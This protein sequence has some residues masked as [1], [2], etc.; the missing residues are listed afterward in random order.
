M[1]PTNNNKYGRNRDREPS[2]FQKQISTLAP[3]VHFLKVCYHGASDEDLLHQATPRCDA[4]SPLP[5]SRSA[6]L[7]RDVAAAAGKDHLD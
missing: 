6:L 3:E 4:L 5:P 2:F 7:W 1:L